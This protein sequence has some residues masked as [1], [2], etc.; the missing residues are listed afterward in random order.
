MHSI[1]SPADA[2]DILKGG[3]DGPPCLAGA[4][5]IPRVSV[6]SNLFPGLLVATVLGFVAACSTEPPSLQAQASP[7]T[8]QNVS[9]NINNSFKNPDVKVDMWADRFTG[10]SRE[11]FAER[12]NVL[13][14]LNLQPGDRIVDIGAGTG[15]YVKL[16]AETVGDTGKVY[17]ND[18]SEPFLKFIEKNAA[19]DG[20]SNVETVLGADK[21]TGLPDSSVDVVFHSDV[22]HHF[23]Y[24][25]TMVR[26]I[27]RTL[28]ADGEMFVLDFER[29]EGVTPQRLLDH[30]RAGKEVVVKEIESSGFRLV[31]EIELPNL[32]ENY[33][34]RFRKAAL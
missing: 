5:I 15:L 18:I 28:V 26:D 21:T 31:E 10:E 6:P 14:A 32:K 29:V 16:F 25:Q 9:P 20:L 19:S 17:A 1:A 24:P 3:G 7:A 12:L 23:E 27:A 33:L 22:Y 13:A 11:V 30:V 2:L 8:E 4:I 34:L